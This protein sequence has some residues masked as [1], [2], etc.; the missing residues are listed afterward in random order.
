MKT[1]WV[2]GERNDRW[3]ENVITIFEKEE[4]ARSAFEDLVK[5]YINEDEFKYEEGDDQ[6]TWTD[7]GNY[8]CVE[9]WEQEVR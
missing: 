8:C 3:S 7:H 1:V 4:K 5:G 9:I 6:A 2:I